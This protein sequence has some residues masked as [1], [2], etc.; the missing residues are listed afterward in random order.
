[1]RRLSWV[2]KDLDEALIC[3]GSVQ[4]LPEGDPV[5]GVTRRSKLVLPAIPHIIV[6]KG[7][8]EICTE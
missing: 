7:E 5:E 4:G 2:C 3:S 8:E 1:M 6:T